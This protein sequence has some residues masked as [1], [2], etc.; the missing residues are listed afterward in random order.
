[1]RHNPGYVSERPM[2]G[3]EVFVKRG[4]VDR[5]K[6]AHDSTIT[7]IN[8][9]IER[10]VCE[11]CGNVSI[12]ASEGLSGTASRSQFEREIERAEQPTQLA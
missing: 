2:G 6:C 5:A 11:S 7:V 4:R 12:N 9:G 3:I 1:M 10:T 8:A